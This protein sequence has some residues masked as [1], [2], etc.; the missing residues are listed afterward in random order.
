[1]VK[2][3]VIFMAKNEDKS[4]ATAKKETNPTRVVSNINT[5]VARICYVR[6]FLLKIGVYITPFFNLEAYTYPKISET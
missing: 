1:M 3:Q 5:A 2:A 6:L 4:R